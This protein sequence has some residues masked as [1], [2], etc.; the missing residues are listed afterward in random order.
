M[1]QLIWGIPVL[2][3][4]AGACSPASSPQARPAATPDASTARQASTTRASADKKKTDWEPVLVGYRVTRGSTPG[5]SLL[6]GETALEPG[7]PVFVERRGPGSAGVASLT[8][9]S[10]PLD[11]G[12]VL[13]AMEYDEDASESG[14]IRWSPMLVVRRGAE[15]STHVGFAGGDGRNL[16]LTVR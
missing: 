7:R 12:N 13:L 10:R 15:V 3:C 11:G 5:D 14:K 1:Q 8:I 2:I 9:R 4:A 16:W 6:E